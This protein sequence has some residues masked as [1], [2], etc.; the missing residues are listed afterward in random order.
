MYKLCDFSINTLKY[1]YAEINY[2]INLL[3]LENLIFIPSGW[4]KGGLRNHKS[5]RQKAALHCSTSE[6]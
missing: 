1:F 6:N 4:A 5:I 3:I 2:M